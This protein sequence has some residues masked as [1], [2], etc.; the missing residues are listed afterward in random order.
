M[1]SAPRKNVTFQ[2]KWRIGNK[3]SSKPK[4]KAAEAALLAG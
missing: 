4:N 1:Q 3:K 2:G